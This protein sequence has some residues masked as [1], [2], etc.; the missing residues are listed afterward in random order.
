MPGGMICTHAYVQYLP[1][2]GIRIP[3]N[4]GVGAGANAS[5]DYGVDTVD[6]DGGYDG[7]QLKWFGYALA[8]RSLYLRDTVVDRVALRCGGTSHVLHEGHISAACW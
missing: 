5:R 2:A 7:W 6:A 1:F 3:R 8:A 4:R